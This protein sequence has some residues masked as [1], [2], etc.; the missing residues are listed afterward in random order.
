MDDFASVNEVYSK[1]FTND[2][3]YPA[4]ATV[5]VKQLPLKNGVQSLVEIAAVAVK[6]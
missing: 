5:V 1:F 2:Q 6:A 3:Q 4:R